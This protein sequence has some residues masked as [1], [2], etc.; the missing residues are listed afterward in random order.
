MVNPS[1]SATD[2]SV[3]PWKDSKRNRI[4]LS[5][6]PLRLGVKT[7]ESAALENEIT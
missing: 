6:D 2:K 7:I 1:L 4:S 3:P 5:S